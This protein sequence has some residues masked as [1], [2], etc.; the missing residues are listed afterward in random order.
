MQSIAVLHR[1]NLGA[2]RSR[3]NN[4]LKHKN[5]NRANRSRHFSTQ[6]A[7]MTANSVD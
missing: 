1:S 7:A 4:R 5:L 3:V 6:V 2:H